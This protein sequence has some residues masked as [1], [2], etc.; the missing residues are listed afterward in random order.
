VTALRVPEAV[1]GGYV[2]PAGS[3][4]PVVEG[5]GETPAM[6]A[7]WVVDAPGFHPLWSG[8][9]VGVIHLRDMPGLSPAKRYVLDATHELV[10]VTLEPGRETEVPWAILTPVNVVHQ[11][12]GTDD[13]A[14]A[15]AAWSAWGIVN[16]YLEPEASNGPERI[17]AGWAVALAETL[18]H[19]RGGGHP[20]PGVP[21]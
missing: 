7:A 15:L 8:Y 10:V 4:R 1:D 12:L 5:L 14:V 16:G 18:E 19:L 13:E 6:L 9:G 3:A 2:G 17:R 11:F 20:H 21:S